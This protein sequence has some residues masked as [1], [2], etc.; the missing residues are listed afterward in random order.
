ML[1]MAPPW[2]E[3]PHIKRHSI[4]WRMGYG[5]WYRHLFCVWFRSCGET[6]RDDYAARFPPSAGWE[7][8]LSLISV[9]GSGSSPL[10]W[11]YMPSTVPNDYIDGSF[12]AR[13]LARIFESVDGDFSLLP[14]DAPVFGMNKIWENFVFGFAVLARD[15]QA[16][17]A[18]A[19]PEPTE[20]EGIYDRIAR[21]ET[22][23]DLPLPGNDADPTNS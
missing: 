2:I 14:R 15:E 7:D 17:F 5:E 21:A 6:V 13:E 20:W 1:E 18:R 16:A 10:P 12:R 9:R 22:F 11:V 23:R 19:N 3:C 4:G 8:F